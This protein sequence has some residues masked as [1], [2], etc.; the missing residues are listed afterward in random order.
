MA[1]ASKITIE[2][3]LPTCPIME[4]NSILVGLGTMRSNEIKQSATKL[5]CIGPEGLMTPL[6]LSC[7]Y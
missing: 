7:S 6:V 2:E 3:W 4:G 1:D 5:Q